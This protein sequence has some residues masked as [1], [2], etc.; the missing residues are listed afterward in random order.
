MEACKSEKTA[1][2]QIR[3]KRAKVKKSP[4]YTPALRAVPWNPAEAW[5][6]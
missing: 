3:Q 5:N 4:D 2:L 6:G 1:G